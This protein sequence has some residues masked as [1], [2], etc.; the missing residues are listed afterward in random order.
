M[1]EFTILWTGFIDFSEGL[2]RMKWSWCTLVL[3]LEK[4]ALSHDS[5]CYSIVDI[6]LLRE[7]LGSYTP[8][9]QYFSFVMSIVICLVG[10]VGNAVVILFLGFI[11]KKHKSKYWFLNLALA[12]F[13][14]LLTLPL[15]AISVLKGT[16]TFGTHFCKFYLFS[17]CANMHA[18]IYI[19][20][21]LNI[22]RVLSVAKPMFHLRFISQRVSLWICSLIWVITG[23]S[24]LP[25]FYFSGEVKIG[26]ST[27]CSYLGCKSFSSVVA[28]Y[29][30]NVSSENATISILMS[31]I[32]T[33]LNPFFEQCSSD[34][35]CGGEETLNFWNHLI[36]T[37]KR[38]AIVFLIIGYFIPLGIVISSNL[39]IVV[40]VRKS[41]TVNPHRLYRS[42]LVIILVY[43]ISW[44]PFVIALTMLFIF[45]LNMTLIPMFNVLIFMPLLITI[46][47]TN[48]C[49]NPIVYVLS[50]GRM[51]TELS[52]FICSFRSNNK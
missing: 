1:L 8:A 14:A 19:L 9:L 5:L 33:K 34:T 15:H 51:R 40:R 12:D 26:E 38:F 11:M 21:A 32:Y 43:F 18:S 37:S 3:A 48:T 20:I 35:C 44:T 45:F 41:K 10:L 49:L 46:A 17:L 30:Y 28:N 25:T 7:Y 31:E 23:L 22:A 13:L 39:I 2:V 4:M 16:W 29:G 42:V 24:C 50:G 6:R 47:Y 36:F 52:D 27:L